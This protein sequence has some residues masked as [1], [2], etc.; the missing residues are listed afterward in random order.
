MGMSA[1][2]ITRVSTDVLS[3]EEAERRH[4]MYMRIAE[5][6]LPVALLRW[7]R[8]QFVSAGRAAFRHGKHT[9]DDQMEMFRSALR[10]YS[11]LCEP[12]Y[13]PIILRF[14]ACLRRGSSAHMPIELDTLY[15]YILITRCRI[16]SGTPLDEKL[17]HT[18]GSKM[19]FAIPT[20]RS[21]CYSLAT[22][23]AD[24]MVR[25][26]SLFNVDGIGSTEVA[27]NDEALLDALRRCMVEVF[28]MCVPIKPLASTERAMAEALVASPGVVP[29]REEALPV[30]EPTEAH[31]QSEPP[32]STVEPPST[33]PI[34]APEAEPT[35]TPP[36]AEPRR[37]PYV[38]WDN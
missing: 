33:S 3:Y 12:Q 31:L 17:E 1:P 35:P 34:L 16:L 21:F 7:Y 8:E 18:G 32:L 11:R 26:R 30:D 6:C 19:S 2:Q 37:A 5:A 15:R 27:R 4:A 13:E 29:N 10:M 25:L 38:D 23:T 14:E 24:V 28:W 20:V 9:T 36:V 22:H